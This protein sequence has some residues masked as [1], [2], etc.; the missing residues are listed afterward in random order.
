MILRTHV[1]ITVRCHKKESFDVT[2]E[3]TVHKSELKLIFKIGNRP[4]SPD[5][6]RGML[7]FSISHEKALEGITLYP[8]I[9]VHTVLDHVQA[10][11]KREYGVFLRVEAERDDQAVKGAERAADYL[12]VS[13]V[14]RVKCSRINSD[15]FSHALVSLL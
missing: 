12:Q 6:R 3:F 1:E 13:V 5:N 4:E 9:A 8:G 11:L 15:F 7:P 10:L 2:A 14:K